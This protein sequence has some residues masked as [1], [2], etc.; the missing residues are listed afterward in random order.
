MTSSR[1]GAAADALPGTGVAGLA[2]RRSESVTDAGAT[3]SSL[4]ERGILESVILPR[5]SRSK[6]GAHGIGDDCAELLS[7]ELDEILLIT[8]DPCPTP[9]VFELGDRDYWHFGWMTILINVSDLAAMG[10]APVGIVVSTVMPEDQCVG[11]YDR[12]LE[13]LTAAADTW[14]CPI[15]GGNI[16]DGPDFTATGTA[17][18]TVS[19]QRV[20]RRIGA[21]SGDL[22]FV[23]GN[24]GLFW[25]SVLAKVGRDDLEL[26]ADTRE[27]LHEALHRPVARLAE[28]RVLSSLGVVSSCMDAS[29]GVS[30]CLSEIARVNSLDIVIENDLFTPHSAV[31]EVAE[32]LDTDFRKLMLSWG[33]WELVFTAPPS[34]H[35]DIERLAKAHNMPVQVLGYTREGNGQVLLETDQKIYRMTDFSS[36]RFAATSY[37]THG[38][39]SFSTWLAEAPLV[40]GIHQ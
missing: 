25:A 22:V 14:G 16:K 5:V 3:L 4:G 1:T 12:F 9:V 18:G 30:G 2:S 35:A 27:C 17:M 36:Q 8:T 15:L 20:M 29:D 28:G 39:K 38:I 10:G 24:M 7:A 26:T 31:R 34:A 32:K 23:V 11:D 33:N 21:Q 13:G 40:E 6:A 37:F 19:A